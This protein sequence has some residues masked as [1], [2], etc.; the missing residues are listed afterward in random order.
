MSESKARLAA[1]VVGLK[2]TNGELERKLVRLLQWARDVDEAHEDVTFPA[3]PDT[4]S[5]GVWRA[6]G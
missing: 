1:E 6:V 4:Y 2:R 5:E 3:L